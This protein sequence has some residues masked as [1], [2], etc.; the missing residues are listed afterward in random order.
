MKQKRNMFSKLVLLLSI[1]VNAAEQNF[2]LED[3]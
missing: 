1:N 2:V 3:T